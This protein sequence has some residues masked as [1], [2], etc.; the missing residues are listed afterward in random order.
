MTFETVPN[1][2]DIEGEVPSSEVIRNRRN[3]LYMGRIHPKKGIE[4]LI[5]AFELLDGDTSANHQLLIAGTGDKSYVE[6]LK[7]IAILSPC[8]GAIKFL[9]H[10]VGKEKEK[11]YKMAKVMVLPSYSENF[12]NVVLESLTFATPVIASRKTP[13]AE[14]QKARCGMWVKNDPQSL[15]RAMKTILSLDEVAY[16]NMAKAAR[17]FAE[18]NYDVR[19]NSDR[20][21]TLYRSYMT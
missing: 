4:N 11:I 7:K 10:C 19:K 1:Y 14:L 3:I 15:A 9:G 17:F 2:I 13:W 20:L 6:T 21:I 16:I 18:E 8:S 12:G 5:S